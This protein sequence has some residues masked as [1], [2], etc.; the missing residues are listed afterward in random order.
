VHVVFLTAILPQYRLPFHEGVRKRLA[1]SQIQYD[2]IFG[3]PSADEEAKGGLA[4]LSWG[5]KIVNHRV[6]IGRISA[7]WQPALRDIWA[8]DLVVIGQENRLLVNYVI[9]SLRRVCRPRVAFWGHGRNFQAAA[10]TGYAERWKRLWATRCDWWFAYTESTRKIVEAYGFPTDRITVFYNA[11]DTS[12]IRRLAS[13]I[14][15]PRLEALRRRLS[16]E[17][18]HI[19]VY[20]G[21][22]YEQ[23]RIGFLLEAAQVVRH[24][25]P[26]FVLIVV[27]AGVDR[28]EVEAAA[29]QHSWIRY[30]GPLFGAEKVE[31]LRLGRVF[32]MPGLVGLAILDCG[33]AALPIVTTA[34]P[35]H[36]PEIAYLEPGGNG[37][38]VE[39]WKDPVAYAK[40][41]VSVLEDDALQTKLAAGAAEIGAAYSIER[42]VECF[43][44]GLSRAVSL[45]KYRG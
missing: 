40:A 19:G 23:K 33:A 9:Q 22:I 18:N 11:V 24:R 13:E 16:I 6:G 39:D 42:M 28:N 15:G 21:G 44:D 10:E 1:A 27:G 29:R 36:S 5:K 17:T 43:S 45:P 12:E 20:V 25:I 38:M 8:S 35:Y 37:L 3:Q 7:I 26:D 30:L 31:I 4:N 41:V 2:V 14:D 32:M 34:Y